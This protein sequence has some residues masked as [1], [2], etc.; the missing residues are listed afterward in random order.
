MFSETLKFIVSPFSFEVQRRDMFTQVFSFLLKKFVNLHLTTENF[1]QTYIM[2]KS[3]YKVL[4]TI[5]IQMY[6][7]F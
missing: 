5:N 7:H 3:G 4:I 1:I 2:L 6:L